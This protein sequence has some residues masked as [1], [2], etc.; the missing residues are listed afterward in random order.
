MKEIKKFITERQVKLLRE[1]KE[2]LELCELEWDDSFYDC[3][4]YTPD[5]DYGEEEN[6]KFFYGCMVAIDELNDVL[7]K[8]HIK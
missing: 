2:E 3:Y 6:A 4:N 5:F 7:I 8:L 1:A